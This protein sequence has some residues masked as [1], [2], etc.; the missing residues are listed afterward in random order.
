MSGST[1]EAISLRRLEW[2]WLASLCVAAMIFCLVTEA[3][4]LSASVLIT[5]VACV[6]LAAMGRKESYLVG[7]YNSAAY[8]WIAYQN[9]LFGEVGLNLAF[10]LPT[11]VLGYFMWQRRSAG[12]VVVMRALS[13]RGRL[14]VAAACL[15]TT[16]ALGW[17]LSLIPAQNTPYIDASTN[18]LSIAATLLMM[19]RFKE[20]WLLYML[21]NAMTIV[22]WLLR[23]QQQGVAGDAMVV[24]WTLFLANSVFGYWRWSLGAAANHR[25]TSP[26]PPA[27]A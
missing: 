9:Q 22:M 25:E 17:A 27:L 8:A 10:Y 6:S 18:V 26:C 13:G 14:A 20:Q 3:D 4:P 16:A 12:R 11:G 23:W 7:L 19:W 5:G 15:L 21:L 2:A 24:M 1:S